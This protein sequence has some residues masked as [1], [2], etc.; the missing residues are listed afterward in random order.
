MAT[1]ALEGISKYFGT[2]PAVQDL[3]CTIAQGELLA[4]LGPS[5]CG[6]T[7]MLLMLVGIYRPGSGIL[8]FDSRIVND[9]PPRQRNLDSRTVRTGTAAALLA[10]NTIQAAYLGL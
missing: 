9:L 3:S 6:K 8:R 7:T 2:V 1:V 5:H 10:D 4:L